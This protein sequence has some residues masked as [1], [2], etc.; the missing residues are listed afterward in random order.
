ML[1]VLFVGQI[2]ESDGGELTGV[3]KGM[4]ECL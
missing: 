1:V 4:G 2:A 3:A